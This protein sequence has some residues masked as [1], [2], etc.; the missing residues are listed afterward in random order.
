LA[1]SAI[2]SYAANNYGIIVETNSAETFDLFSF[3]LIV[4]VFLSGIVPFYFVVKV[5]VERFSVKTTINTE[6]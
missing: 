4:Y 6:V 3:K 2:A 5:K 1:T